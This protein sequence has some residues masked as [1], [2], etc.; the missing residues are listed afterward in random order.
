M[1]FTLIF[2]Y[3]NY[4]KTGFCF[5][6]KRVGGGGGVNSGTSFVFWF[7]LSPPCSD[8]LISISVVIFSSLPQKPTIPTHGHFI[9]SSFEL[10]FIKK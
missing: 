9:T 7:S 3:S 1:S 5:C 4:I 8:V 10:F 6:R 2:L